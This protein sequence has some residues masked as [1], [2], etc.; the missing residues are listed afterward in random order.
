MAQSSN[1]LYSS[2]EL[3]RLASMQQ[4][5]SRNYFRLREAHRELRARAS[6]QQ[7]TAGAMLA[8]GLEAERRRLGRELHTG[9]GQAL[10]G[11]HVHA[12]ILETLL[13]DPPERVRTTL[14]RIT[15]LA[16]AAL[17]QVRGVSRKLYVP[18]WQAL[19]LTEALRILWDESGIPEK[20]SGSLELQEL[21]AEPPADVRRALYL[22]AQE[23]ISNVIRHADARHVRLS[24]LRADGRILLEVED[25]GS[26]FGS[27]ADEPPGEPVAGIGLR[28][29]RDL[30]AELGGA[31]ETRSTPQGANLSISFPVTYEQ[32]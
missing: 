1:V 25:D 3:E 26:G 8:D 31:L 27:S 10:A 2:R 17:E 30:A 32:S 23:G 16:D 21:T 12:G 14:H 7:K 19:P 9:V 18:A 4:R 22:A 20:F 29:L 28:A 13:P 11:I 15:A 6:E 24:L 5:L